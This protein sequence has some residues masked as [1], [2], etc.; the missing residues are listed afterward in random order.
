M[1]YE[2]DEMNFVLMH[3]EAVFQVSAKSN[4]PTAL[5]M[6]KISKLVMKQKAVVEEDVDKNDPLLSDGPSTSSIPVSPVAHL[7]ASPKVVRKKGKKVTK[8]VEVATAATQTAPEVI[9]VNLASDDID[10]DLFKLQSM[11]QNFLVTTVREQDF[12]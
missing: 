7:P 10:F 11:R 6:M 1:N 3:K 4:L 12:N 2:C 9:S 8:L 5:N